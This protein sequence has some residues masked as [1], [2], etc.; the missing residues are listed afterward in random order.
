MIVVG[1][2][3]PAIFLD[4]GNDSLSAKRLGILR[5]MRLAVQNASV[6]VIVLQED[7][8]HLCGLEPIEIPPYHIA[9]FVPY[10]DEAED[11]MCPQAFQ[12]P[13]EPTKSLLID[14]WSDERYQS[15][16]GWDIIPK[17]VV[18]AEG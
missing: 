9:S 2:D 14:L 4:E 6:G 7:Q 1:V 11:H 15:C 10:W 3:S 13:P 16:L 8:S 17:V 5:A 12:V 18:D